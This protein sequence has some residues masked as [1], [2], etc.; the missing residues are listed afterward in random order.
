MAAKA[1]TPSAVTDFDLIAFSLKTRF[2][3]QGIL[4]GPRQL[5]S[6]RNH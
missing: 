4:A 2:G 5:S 3:R 1:S 6:W